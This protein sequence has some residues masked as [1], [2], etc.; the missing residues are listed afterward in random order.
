MTVSLQAPP[1]SSA[2]VTSSQLETV[3][4]VWNLAGLA[5]TSGHATTFVAM[6]VATERSLLEALTTVDFDDPESVARAVEMLRRWHQR[7]FVA[8]S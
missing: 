6:A 1:A 5:P 3:Q 4:R 2:T 7:R 8:I